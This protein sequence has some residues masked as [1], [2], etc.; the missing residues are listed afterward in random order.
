MRLEERYELVLK[1]IEDLKEASLAAPVIVEGKN[2][3]KALRSMGIRGNIVRLNDGSPIF[4]TCEEVSR[5]HSS[6][7]I[8]TDWDQRGGQLCR[9]LREGLAANGV[10]YDADIRSRLARLCRKEVKDVEGLAR[11]V[12]RI[13]Q[14]SAESAIPVRRRPQPRSQRPPHG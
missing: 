1:T 8:L 2:D 11:Y 13:L 12:D 6:A 5:Q 14:A 4:R 10:R 9:L 3:R 7:V